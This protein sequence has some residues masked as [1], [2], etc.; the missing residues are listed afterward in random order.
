MCFVMRAQLLIRNMTEHFLE[1]H[2]A[3]GRQMAVRPMTVMAANWQPLLE[4]PEF[5]SIVVL[6]SCSGR[7]QVRARRGHAFHLPQE[8]LLPIL[9]PPVCKL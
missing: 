5:I 2:F 7:S 3:A 4:R 1:L 8:L 9:R 6:T